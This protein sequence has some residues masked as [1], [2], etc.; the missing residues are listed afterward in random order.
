MALPPVKRPPSRQRPEAAGELQVTVPREAAEALL[1]LVIEVIATGFRIREAGKR[2]GTVTARGGGLW[3]LLRS[4]TM[5]G[6]STVPQVARSRPVS[7]QH[8][9]KIADELAE[10]GLIEFVDNPDHRRSK[11]MRL[12]PKGERTYAEMTDRVLQ[13]LALVVG[14]LEQGEIRAATRTLERLRRRLVELA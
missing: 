5:N 11:L 13:R 2:Q 4:L 10:R 12:T 6:P 9:Q 3:G 8:I 7:R 1:D 14:G